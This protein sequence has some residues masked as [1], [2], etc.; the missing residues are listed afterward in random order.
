[1]QGSRAQLRLPRL[2]ELQ[3]PGSACWNTNS[4]SSR[5]PEGW[6]SDRHSI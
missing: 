1:M 3:F 2:V 5:L 4:G 6:I